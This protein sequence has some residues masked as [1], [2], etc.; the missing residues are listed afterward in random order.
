[1][2]KHK[3]AGPQAQQGV[4]LW[5]PEADTGQLSNTTAGEKCQESQLL[6]EESWA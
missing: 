5:T 1:M 2:N 4:M 3:R 6:P